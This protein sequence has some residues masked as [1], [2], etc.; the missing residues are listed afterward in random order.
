MAK[1]RH[2]GLNQKERAKRNGSERSVR[3]DEV[4]IRRINHGL[5]SFRG[6]S[7]KKCPRCDDY[8]FDEDRNKHDDCKLAPVPCARRTQPSAGRRIPKSK[9]KKSR[10]RVKAKHPEQMSKRESLQ[11]EFIRS[12]KFNFPVSEISCQGSS[13]IEISV[14]N[15]GLLAL[16]A[17]EKEAS[18]IASTYA[19]SMGIPHA[20]CCLFHGKKFYAKGR[21]R[22]VWANPL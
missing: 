21:Y 22:S 16:E 5:R 12:A 18:R 20:I 17:A 1:G 4:T 8:Y 6:K 2:E 13:V 15:I 10:S 14:P 9:G 7:K 11:T 19:Q 3:L